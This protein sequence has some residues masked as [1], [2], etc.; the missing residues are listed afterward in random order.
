LRVVDFRFFVSLALSFDG[1]LLNG[2]EFVV[3]HSYPFPFSTTNEVTPIQPCGSRDNN[4]GHK[5][6]LEPPRYVVEK[7]ERYEWGQQTRPRCEQNSVERE[8]QRDQKAKIGNTQG[9]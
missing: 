9:R 5:D 4:D 3:T 8:C 7:G 6:G 2:D 1:I